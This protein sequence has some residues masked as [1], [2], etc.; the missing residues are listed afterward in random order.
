MSPLTSVQVAAYTTAAGEERV[1]QALR[2]QRGFRLND[3]PATQGEGQAYLVEADLPDVEELR[4]VVMD[5]LAQ[6]ELSGLVPMD[7]RR[8]YPDAPE[9]VTP[10]QAAA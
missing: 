6:T 2:G 5:Y 1:L 4:G 8:I 3:L 9:W 7:L 10:K